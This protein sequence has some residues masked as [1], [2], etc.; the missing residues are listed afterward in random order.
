MGRGR[1]EEKAEFDEDNKIMELIYNYDNTD[2][3][4][5]QNCILSLSVLLWLGSF[6]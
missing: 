2:E 6:V 1:E 5:A 4:G 3:H